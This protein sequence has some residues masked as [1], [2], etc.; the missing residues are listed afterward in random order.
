MRFDDDGDND[1]MMMMMIMAKFLS[2]TRLSWE[3]H[4]Y[5]NQRDKSKVLLPSTNAL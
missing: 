4:D 3:A 2:E 1:L 5:G